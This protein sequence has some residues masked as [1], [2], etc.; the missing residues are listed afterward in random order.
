MA[1]DSIVASIMLWR[2]HAGDRLTHHAG[3]EAPAS[4]L[5]AL[6]NEGLRPHL[7]ESWQ[8]HICLFI[9]NID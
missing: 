1:S 9:F 7:P 8:V 4:N 5:H 6:V 2:L 3:G